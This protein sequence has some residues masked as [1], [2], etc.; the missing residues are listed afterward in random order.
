[1]S[2]FLNTAKSLLMNLTGRINFG[3]YFLLSIPTTLVALAFAR[4]V[5][6]V[7]AIL[8]IY[9]ATILN[10]LLLVEGVFELVGASNK[11]KVILLFLLKVAILFGALAFGV[12]LMGKRVIIPLLNYVVIIFVLGISLKNK[13][14][15]PI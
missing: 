10:Q 13:R 2:L 8:V 15:N 5:N 7:L 14:D 3:R 11:T 12:H 6:E 4:G 9:L 1:M